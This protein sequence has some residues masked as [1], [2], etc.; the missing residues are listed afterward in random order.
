MLLR[1][2]F[3][4]SLGSH[5]SLLWL[6]LPDYYSLL[7]FTDVVGTETIPSREI[8]LE[9]IEL[10]KEQDETKKTD[11][12]KDAD[13]GLASVHATTAR[14]GSRDADVA[15]QLQGSKPTDKAKSYGVNTN[16]PSLDLV[17]FLPQALASDG[18]QIVAAAIDLSNADALKSFGPSIDASAGIRL[19]FS[20]SGL[21]ATTTC[22][23]LVKFGPDFE[24]DHGSLACRLRA[25][26]AE[27]I[28]TSVVTSSRQSDAG[29]IDI[30]GD[31][32]WR[33]QASRWTHW[34]H[35]NTS[36]RTIFLEGG[37]RGDYLLIGPNNALQHVSDLNEVWKWTDSFP[38]G[39]QAEKNVLAFVS[40]Q[41]IYPEVLVSCKPSRLSFSLEFADGGYWFEVR[42]LF[43]STTEAKNRLGCVH[44][45]V[46]R[47]L[48]PLGPLFPS[49]KV[50]GKTISARMSGGPDLLAL[51]ADLTESF[52]GTMSKKT[53]QS[54][55]TSQRTSERERDQR[56][57]AIARATPC[58]VTPQN[59][60]AALTDYLDH[61]PF[62]VG[63]S[64]A[65]EKLAEVDAG[66]GGAP[67]TDGQPE[68]G[69]PSD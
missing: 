42:L 47:F 54:L 65:R 12:T 35:G 48:G 62:G 58:D 1:I 45:G 5:L 8:D 55:S 23:T 24:E 61:H 27:K 63:A 6:L 9:V 43:V 11:E 18:R 33:G 29:G 20:G 49:P 59:N 21:D 19:M 26:A 15:A 22:I 44:A 32:R 57:W 39:G 68:V 28:R 50:T 2:A 13:P 30:P 60:C 64:E 69:A 66:L 46:R 7:R 51:I 16:A 67:A 41:G 56:E 14:V 52:V 37:S 36:D 17:S 3:Y 40:S 34:P 25:G 31:V 38:S 10:P 4:V 53:A